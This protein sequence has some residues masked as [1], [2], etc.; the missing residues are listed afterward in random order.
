MNKCYMKGGSNIE[1]KTGK[2]GGRYKMR[3]FF[4]RLARKMPEIG[5]LFFPFDGDLRT[6]ARAQRQK[7]AL[8]LQ[9]EGKEKQFIN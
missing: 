5:L 3:M 8:L 4:Y 6:L 9:Q 2:K 7:R 1:Y